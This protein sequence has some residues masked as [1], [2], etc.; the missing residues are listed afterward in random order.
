MAT[1]NKHTAL[2]GKV[3]YRVQVRLKGYPPDS[4][5]FSRLADAKRWAAETEAAI[6]QGRHFGV[7]RRRTFAELVTK[8]QASIDGELKS[9]S[10]RAG[11]FK[12][13]K[14]KFDGTLHDV[15]PELVARAYADLHKDGE[16]T[17]STANRYLA[18]LSACFS[19][20]VRELGWIERNPCARVRKGKEPPGRVR[21]LTDDE[22]VRL[23]DACK[24]SRNP[25][26]YRAFVVALSTGARQG[27]IMNL[28]W[29]QVDFTRKTIL[30]RDGETKNDS[31]R[32]LPLVGEAFELLQ[33]MWK[34]RGV[35]DDRV[36]R[37]GSRG[38]AFASLREAWKRA[39]AR[40]E[41]ADFSWHDLRHTAA[42][43]LVMSG[44]GGLEVGK[45]LG[46]KT[47]QMTTRYVHLAPGH[48]VSMGDVLAKRL[49]LD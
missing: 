19:Y 43:Y 20:A 25:L 18:S 14:S 5:T 7:A 26:L 15:T 22:R 39:R 2:D 37:V 31:G 23:I 42:S 40:A 46:H 17:V 36:F 32:V 16:R 13:W 12:Y 4:A 33:A 38:R 24:K 28:R 6:R 48:V 49:G 27:E 34:E 11:H 30:L 3:S 41:V 44:V 1:I 8:Y 21:Y 45:L 29:D 10:A 47:P 9:A 35:S